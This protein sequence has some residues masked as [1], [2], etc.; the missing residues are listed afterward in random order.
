MSVATL[1]NQ[2]LTLT[3]LTIS[4]AEYSNVSGYVP[5]SS[6][7]SS[8]KNGTTLSTSTL[9]TSNIYSNSVFLTNGAS[10]PPNLS[11]SASNNVIL[12][13]PNNCG[14]ELN[15]LNGTALLSA[16]SGGLSINKALVLNMNGA[17]N[18][19]SISSTVS[20]NIILSCPNGSGI[21]INTALKGIS[22]LNNNTGL[23]INAPIYL[24]NAG[25]TNAP[26]ISSGSSNS[27]I[28]SCPNNSGLTL[29]TPQGT[30]TLSVNS[31]GGLTW[32]G[33]QIS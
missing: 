29:S 31:T 26:N 23:S 21:E 24:D 11:S 1:E 17:T 19:P 5:S 16:V 25:T 2:D 4:N 14:L 7:F 15:T 18:A 12:S 27:V 32:N 6:S 10:L 20:N 30:G 13:S 8:T 9:T 33:I 28:I 3:S 22:L